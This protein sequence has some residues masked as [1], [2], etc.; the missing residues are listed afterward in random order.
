MTVAAAPRGV[1]VGTMGMESE[2][3]SRLAVKDLMAKLLIAVRPEDSVRLA[4]QRVLDEKI[5]A[6][7]VL[8]GEGRPLGLLSQADLLTA[9]MLE[10]P[11]TAEELMSGRM[12]MVHEAA[13]LVVATGTMATERVHRLIVVDDLGHAV[14]MLSSMD[15]LCWLA[16]QAGYDVPDH[17]PT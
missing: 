14:G 17:N 5:S 13:S 8:D 9:A 7:P 10:E 15:V 16:K 12:V 4:T 2:Q 6:V 11:M 3:S 1:Y